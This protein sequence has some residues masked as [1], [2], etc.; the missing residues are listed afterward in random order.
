MTDS[1]AEHDFDFT[2]EMDSLAAVFWEKTE[3]AVFL[4]F[5]FQKS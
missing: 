2:K 3:T 1:Y 4:K 5:F